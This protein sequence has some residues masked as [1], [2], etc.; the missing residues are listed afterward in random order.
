MN[1]RPTLVFK[2][3]LAGHLKKTIREIDQMDS[4]EFSQWIAFGKYFE[5]FGDE[6]RQAGVIAAASLT[7][8]MRRG[9][10]VEAEDFMPIDK[11]KPQHHT[12]IADN[13]RRLKKDL[14][15]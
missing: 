10:D 7:P 12:Q 5:P 8:H 4:R 14:G 6:W 15:L 1:A 13:A 11:H 3:R 2:F 9:T